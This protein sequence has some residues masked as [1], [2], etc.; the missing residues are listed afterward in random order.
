MKIAVVHSWKHVN[1]LGAL[2]GKIAELTLELVVHI[3][4][5]V[6]EINRY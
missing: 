6:F 4:T 1:H 3:A 5:N 2:C